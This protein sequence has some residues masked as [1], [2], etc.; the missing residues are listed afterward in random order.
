VSGGHFLSE[1]MIYL[2][3]EPGEQLHV[4]YCIL[5]DIHLHGL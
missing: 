3:F 1:E 4:Q 5:K 2:V